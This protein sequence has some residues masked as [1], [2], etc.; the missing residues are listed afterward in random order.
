MLYTTPPSTAYTSDEK[1]LAVEL[2]KLLTILQVPHDK[3]LDDMI[4]ASQKWRRKPGQE[5][6]ELKDLSID[7]KTHQQ[8]MDQ[9]HRLDMM[10]EIK[11]Q[12]QEYDYVLLLGATIPR[13]RQRLEHLVR[14][15]QQGIRFHRLV[16]LVGLRPLTRDVDQ[17]EQLVIKAA[18]HKA[19]PEAWPVN[20]LEGAEM[21]YRSTSMPEAMSKVPVDYVDTR[22][23]WAHNRWHRANTRDTAITWFNKHPKPGK[24]LVISEQ[25]SAHYQHEVVRQELPE[26]FIVDLAAMPAPSETRLVLALDALALWLHNIRKQ[27]DYWM[28]PPKAPSQIALP[29]TR[30]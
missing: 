14:L 10:G 9:L 15:W 8:A 23:R 20:E 26:R 18:G 5:R 28:V 29:P 2:D 11:P 7:Q 16:F 21:L 4:A 17:V 13:M 19:S 22:R 3:T 27:P 1:H 24:T 6:W 12:Y 25:P 30:H